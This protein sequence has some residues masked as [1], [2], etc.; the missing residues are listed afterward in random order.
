MTTTTLS[1]S[2]LDQQIKNEFGAL[3]ALAAY[4]ENLNASRILFQD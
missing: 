4:V 2:Q 1:P 3:P